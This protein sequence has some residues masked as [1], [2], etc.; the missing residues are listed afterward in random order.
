MLLGGAI[1]IMDY[2]L[3]ENRV[4]PL[5]ANL[6]QLIL[7]NKVDGKHRTFAEF[8]KLLE[9]NGF[10]ETQHFRCDDFCIYDAIIAKKL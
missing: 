10:G 6:T 1:L 8:S 5:C 9:R 3:N 7:L 2:V 4:G